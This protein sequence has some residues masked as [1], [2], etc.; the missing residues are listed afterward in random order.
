MMS[1][2]IELKAGA[3]SPFNSYARAINVLTN[4]GGRFGLTPSDRSRLIVGENHAK[5]DLISNG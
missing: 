1:G 2:K 4:L 3:A 5:D